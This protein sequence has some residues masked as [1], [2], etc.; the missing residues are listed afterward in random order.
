MYG[1]GWPKIDTHN[2]TEAR[3]PKNSWHQNDPRPHANDGSN[4][5]THKEQGD[6]S[7]TRG[8]VWASQLYPVTLTFWSRWTRQTCTSENGSKHGS[9]ET[10]NYTQISY[11]NSGKHAGLQVWWISCSLMTR[12]FVSFKFG[13][14]ILARFISFGRCCWNFGRPEFVEA[15][16]RKIYADLDGYLDGYQE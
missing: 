13:A 2:C 9:I 10:V 15:L 11:H 14:K 7:K 4:V 16:W 12:N 6:R 3:I 5:T 8:K 1:T